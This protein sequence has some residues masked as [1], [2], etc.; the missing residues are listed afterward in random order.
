MLKISKSCCNMTKRADKNKS[1]EN[2]HQVKV[3]DLG[4]GIH[5]DC[6]HFKEQVVHSL[7]LGLIQF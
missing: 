3:A 7:N 5:Q 2:N 6:A 1:K 4:K